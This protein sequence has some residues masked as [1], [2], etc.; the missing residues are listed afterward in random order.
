MSKKMALRILELDK[1]AT[2]GPWLKLKTVGS[3]AD[4]VAPHDPIV[5][6][7]LI[8]S[9]SNVQ[10]QDF[11][12]ESRSLAPQIATAYLEALELLAELNADTVASITLSLQERVEKFLKAN[13]GEGV[14][15]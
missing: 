2:P 5:Q 11:I 14:G 10:D 1:E 15:K 4:I 9:D 3:C 7:S 13:E 8:N 12:A 6:E